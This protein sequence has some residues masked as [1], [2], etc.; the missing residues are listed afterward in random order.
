ML[1]TVDVQ[2]SVKHRYDMYRLINCRCFRRKFIKFVT[3]CCLFSLV[4]IFYIF[5]QGS[6]ELNNYQKFNDDELSIKK[7]ES[8]TKENKLSSRGLK[9]LEV[10]EDEIYTIKPPVNIFGEN[11]SVGELG[12]AVILPKD[13][14]I[15]IKKLIDK[16]FRDHS[17]N[18]YLSD[19]IS[20]NRTL[21]DKRTE[22][23]KNSSKNYSSLPKTSVIVTFH[24]EAWSTLLRTIHSILNRSPEQLIEE[25]ILVDDFSSMGE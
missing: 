16:G 11:V 14:P 13:I 10:L 9:I 22:Y 24:N 20:V 5:N 21:K 18:Q 2:Y 15:E 4:I 1:C 23:C 7:E 19:I 6:V 17:F 25:I 8:S 12:E 3:Y